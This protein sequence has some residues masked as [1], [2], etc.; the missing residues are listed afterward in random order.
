MF[1]QL[2]GGAFIFRGRVHSALDDKV[3]WEDKVP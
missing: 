3:D 2:V 1:G